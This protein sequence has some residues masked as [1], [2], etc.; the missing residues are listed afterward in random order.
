MNDDLCFAV[1]I[2]QID[3]DQSAEIAIAGHPALEDDGLIQI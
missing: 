1:T 2:T 3:E